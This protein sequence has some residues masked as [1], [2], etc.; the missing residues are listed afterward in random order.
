MKKTIQII[1]LATLCLFFSDVAYAQTATLKIGDKVPDVTINNISNYKTTSAKLSDFRGKLLIL[2]FWA[3]WC[4]PCISMIPKM[5]SLQQVFDGKIQFLSITYQEAGIVEP[6]MD[7]LQKRHNVHY[8]TPQAV[9]DQVLRSLFPHTNLP[10]YVWIDGEGKV[11]AITGFE[12]VTAANI[13][14]QLREGGFKFEVK[15]DVVLAYDRTKPLF[16][17]GNGGEWPSATYHSLFSRFKDGLPPGFTLQ[18]A[19]SL[20]DFRLVIRNASR[21]W[22]YSLAFGEGKEY[23]GPKRISFEVKEPSQ[24]IRAQGSDNTSQAQLH[25]QEQNTFCYELILPSYM[26]QNAYK[27][28]KQ[29]IT[30]LFPQYEARVEE[31]ATK[32]LVLV[33]INAGA[34]LKTS[35]GKPLSAINGAGSKLQNVSLDWLFLRLDKVYMQN[36]PYPLIN[37]SGVT[38]PVDIEINA[39]LH[40]VAAVNKELEKYGLQFIEAFRNIDMLVINDSKVK[41]IN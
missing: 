19:D 34:N 13:R 4:S 17:N 15:T 23:Y 36:H 29:D 28:M 38:G 40:N 33:P 41:S 5:D 2:D 7:K 16:I 26:A 10:H 18:K 22:F 30:R 27:W 25:W 20:K 1:A 21:L 35:G 6:F 24:F 31:R 8:S 3:T 32:C 9:N 37:E 14:T 12:D 11:K 39:P